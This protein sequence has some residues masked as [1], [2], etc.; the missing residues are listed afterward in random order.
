MRNNPEFYVGTFKNGW[1]ILEISLCGRRV[2]FKI[3]C[4]CGKEKISDY[5]HIRKCALCIGKTK[6]DCYI[7]KTFGL[8]LESCMKFFN[9]T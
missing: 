8:R 9:S 4:L 1:E 7:G 6:S 5:W 2:K 3:R